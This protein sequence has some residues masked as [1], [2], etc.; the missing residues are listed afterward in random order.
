MPRL[1]DLLFSARRGVRDLMGVDDRVGWRDY[2]AAS[3]RQAAYPSSPLRR[4]PSDSRPVPG[5]VPPSQKTDITNFPR[6]P[7][8]IA[9][10]VRI[11]LRNEPPFSAT[12]FSVW[13]SSMF[14]SFHGNSRESSCR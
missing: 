3:A 12:Q 5:P 10:D 1:R 14:I 8:K 11:P 4:L 9:P 2:P 7:L 6:E 13:F